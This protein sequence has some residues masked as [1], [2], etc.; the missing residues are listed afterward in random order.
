MKKT[1]FIFFCGMFFASMQLSYFFMLEAIMSSTAL[2]FFLVTL[3]WLLG[4]ILGLKNFVKVPLMYLIVISAVMFYGLI[5]CL[6]SFPYNANLFIL[7]L[8]FITVSSVFAGTLFKLWSNFTNSSA[9]FF[10]LENNGFLLGI[11]LTTL[12][13]I[14]WGKTFLLVIFA[15]LT[16]ILL[17]WKFFL[18]YE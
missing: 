12:G 9:T 13:F 14:F 15:I 8:I 10:F 11:I 7:Y 5:F 6:H 3:C 2:T 1:L 17:S 16:G 4:I 18:D